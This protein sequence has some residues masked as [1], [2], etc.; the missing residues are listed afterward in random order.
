MR[1]LAEY[2]DETRARTLADALFAEGVDSHVDENREGASVVWVH[3]ERHLD[4]ARELLQQFEADPEDPRF[5][6]ARREAEVRRKKEKE[7]KKQ[8]RHRNVDVRT[9][10]RSQGGIGRVTI[11]LIVITAALTLLARFGDNQRVAGL[12][13]FSLAR[14]VQEGEVWRLVT[15]IFLHLGILHLLFNM[16]WLKD[17]GTVVEQRLSPL[18]LV[19]MVLVMGTL[20][21]AAQALMVGEGFGGM[22]GVVYGLFGYFWVRGRLDPTWGIALHRSTVVILV[23]WFLLGFSGL[24]PTANMAH[25]GGLVVG[26]LWGAGASVRA[27]PR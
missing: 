4:E 22:S 14:I 20:S 13:Y 12:L 8:T 2:E 23:G 25:L 15:P 17:F 10:W 19:A 27:R 6:Q 18:T 21:N 24:M 1:A 3:D 9:Q 5:E 7:E 11:G 26:A 16:W